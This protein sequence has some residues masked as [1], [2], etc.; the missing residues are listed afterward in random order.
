MP[1]VLNYDPYSTAQH[2]ATSN[3]FTPQDRMAHSPGSLSTSLGHDAWFKRRCFA[4][5]VQTMVN[6]RQRRDAMMQLRG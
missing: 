3:N 6:F 4:E 5:R 1:D 2:S